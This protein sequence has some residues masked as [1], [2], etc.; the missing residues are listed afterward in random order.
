MQLR[1]RAANDDTGFDRR[2]LLQ[3][4][5]NRGF[6]FHFLAATPA[7]VRGNDEFAPRVVDAIDQR[8][9]REAA[10]HDRVRRAD[11]RAGEHRDRQF[12]NQRHVQ[13]DAVAALNAGAF[14]HVRELA[15]FG[16]EL[17]IRVGALSPGSPSQMSAALLRRHVFR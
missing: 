9:A 3:C 6:Q 2:R 1:A 5:V 14:E 10:E 12:G 11:T 13:S 7:A 15:H 4:L 16:V 8:L 17:L